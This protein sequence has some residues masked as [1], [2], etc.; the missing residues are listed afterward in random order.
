MSNSKVKV[1]H[2]N[3]PSPGSGGG[4]TIFLWSLTGLLFFLGLAALRDTF[5]V[6]MKTLLAS[7][8]ACPWVHKYIRNWLDT[9]GFERFTKPLLIT[10]TVL[11][12]FQLL[13]YPAEVE[14]AS[15]A[16]DVRQANQEMREY[17]ADNEKKSGPSSADT[18]Q[19]IRN[20]S[21]TYGSHS[22]AVLKVSEGLTKIAESDGGK[23]SCAIA[24]ENETLCTYDDPGKAIVITIDGRTAKA[25]EI[26]R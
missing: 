3:N 2:G 23:Y 22:E 9:K 18:E 20:F 11:A 15:F 19:E 17:I 8:W 24:A 26:Q 12:F 16:G 13:G 10:I 7:A 1:F 4:L 5:G 21:Q 25:Q 6:G 14:Q